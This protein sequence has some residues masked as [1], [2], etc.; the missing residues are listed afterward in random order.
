MEAFREAM[1]DHRIFLTFFSP[2]G[3]EIRKNYPGADH[4][5]YLPADSPEMAAKF[6]KVLSPD[7]VFFIKY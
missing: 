1:P 6:V 7:I 2:S 5:F 4:V 3:Y